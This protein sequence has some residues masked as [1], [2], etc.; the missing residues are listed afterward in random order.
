MNGFCIGRHSK[1]RNQNGQLSVHYFF[2]VALQSHAR[3]F[4]F[5]QS[6]SSNQRDRG[7]N[8]CPLPTILL[9]RYILWANTRRIVRRAARS[10]GG[11][12]SLWL[13]DEESHI[14]RRG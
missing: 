7:G 10:S 4:T 11:F 13:S 12:K 3:Q 9:D 1:G 8:S 2:A 6:Y 14:Q 5:L